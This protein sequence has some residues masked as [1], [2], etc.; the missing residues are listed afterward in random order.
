MSEVYADSIQAKVNGTAQAVPLRDSDAQEKIGSL[1]EDIENIAKEETII[2]YGSINICNPES[3]ESGYYNNGIFQ[4]SETLYHTDFIPVENGDVIRSTY[5]SNFGDS[6]GVFKKSDG[7]IVNIKTLT[8]VTKHTDVSNAKWR[9]MEFVIPSDVT[10][11]SLNFVFSALN[12]SYMITKNNTFPDETYVAY[13]GETKRE[14]KILNK[15]IEFPSNAIKEEN[16]SDD[17]RVK[18]NRKTLNGIKWGA[19]GDSWTEGD[20]TYAKVVSNITGATLS[21][22]G[23]GGTGYKNGEDNGKSFVDRV[24]TIGDDIQVL[25]VFGSFND[26]KYIDDNIG[27]IGDKTTDTLYGAMFKFYDDLFS[28]NTDII[29]G[30]I[31]PGPWKILSPR[32]GSEKAEKYV[33]ALID[34]ADYFSLPTLDLYHESGLRPWDDSFA[35]KYYIEGSVNAVH[36]TKEAHEKFIAPKIVNFINMMIVPIV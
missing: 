35:N 19:F 9:W 28:S 8:E 21:N 17:V 15:E 27:Q 31:T 34:T 25:T 1:S 5:A 33:K 32:S 20:S 11:M 4:S 7:S 12:V 30:I 14:A 23:V 22:L 13:D 3:V 6:Y 16:L 18:F 26:S 2:T 24:S 36:P 10:D 29:V